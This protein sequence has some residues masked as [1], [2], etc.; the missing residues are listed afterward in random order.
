M[1]GKMVVQ[2]DVILSTV[3]QELSVSEDDLLK[4]ALRSILER[5][6]RQVQAEISLI[7]SRYGVSGVEE[8]EA[9][10]RNGTLEEADSWRDWQRL[11][12]LEYKRERLLKLLEDLR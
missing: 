8:M 3:A 7:C 1:E 4:Q 2:T 5:H 10:Y 6:L 12:H 11:D 9:R